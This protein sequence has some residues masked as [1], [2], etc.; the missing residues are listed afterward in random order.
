MLCAALGLGLSIVFLQDGLT[1]RVRAAATGAVA[2]V[3]L[4]L[5]PLVTATFAAAG[6][7][8]SRSAEYRLHLTS[9]I[10]RIDLIGLSG[11]AQRL[12]DGR[13]AFGAFK[14]IDSELI[15]LGLT[16]GG[17]AL[18][19][20]VVLLAVACIAVLLGRATAPTIAIAAQ[21]PSLA[22]VALITQYSAFVWFVAGL[23]VAT[24]VRAMTPDRDAP[25]P[26]VLP[27]PHPSIPDRR[28][29]SLGRTPATVR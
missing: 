25:G 10:G 23:A 2:V 26:D 19:L 4:T 17:V 1:A 29:R 7:E 9:L 18:G 12:S 6:S 21:I 16:Y 3:G 22:T 15:L 27:D 5:V 11:A 8:Q 24:Q 28:T 14:S 20:T 13:L